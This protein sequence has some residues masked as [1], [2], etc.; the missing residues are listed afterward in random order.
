MKKNIITSEEMAQY[1]NENI[2]LVPEASKDRFTTWDIEKQY[3]KVRHYVNKAQIHEEMYV[4]PFSAKTITLFERRHA[5]IYDIEQVI[6][7][8]NTYIDTLKQKQKQHL[9]EQINK[10]QA[11]LDAMN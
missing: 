6:A 2:A 11:E 7:D 4:N 5:T 9:E 1:I 8:C 3:R 10:L